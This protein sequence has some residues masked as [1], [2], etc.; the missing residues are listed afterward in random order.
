MKAINARTA[1]A[2]LRTTCPAELDDLLSANGLT[3][4]DAMSATWV[5][6]DQ[7]G[8]VLLFETTVNG[9]ILTL[10]DTEGFGSP[11]EGDV[12]LTARPDADD[13]E[14]THYAQTDAFYA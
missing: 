14:P 9:V 11:M 12:L 6:L 1:L 2:T 3:E 7:A 10:T 13:S 5:G 4:A 8:H